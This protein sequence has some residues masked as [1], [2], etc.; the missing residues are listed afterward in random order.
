MITEIRL[1]TRQ[2][3]ATTV[4]HE[5]TWDDFMRQVT[6]ATINAKH[7]G[8]SIIIVS[9]PTFMFNLNELA[10]ATV[11]AVHEPTTVEGPTLG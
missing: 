8:A 2:G 1:M 4:R 6:Q 9:F 10:F 5:G 3:A 11:Y 7:N